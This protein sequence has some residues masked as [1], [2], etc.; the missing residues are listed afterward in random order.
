MPV[1]Q[2]IAIA[3][4]RSIRERSNDNERWIYQPFHVAVRGLEQEERAMLTSQ[5]ISNGLANPGDIVTSML[6]PASQQVFQAQMRIQRDVDALQGYRSDPYA[7]GPNRCV[8]GH[9]G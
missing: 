1:A 9:V 6:L 2:V 8:A 4:A 3:A 7:R 5:A